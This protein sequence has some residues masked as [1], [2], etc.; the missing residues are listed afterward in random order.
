MLPPRGC[1]Y[2]HHQLAMP[3]PSSSLANLV[4][5]NCPFGSSLNESGISTHLGHVSVSRRLTS[6]IMFTQQV[7]PCPFFW[8]FFAWL[9]VRRVTAVL[10]CGVGSARRQGRLTRLRKM[11]VR[12]GVLCTAVPPHAQH[13]SS[14]EVRIVFGGLLLLHHIFHGSGD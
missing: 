5:K 2:S 14:L 8:S 7:S 6:F 3:S 1:V 9:P 11:C 13:L 12:G 4:T 10:V